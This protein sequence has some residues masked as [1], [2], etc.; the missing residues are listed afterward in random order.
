MLYGTELIESLMLK[1]EK[2]SQVSENS[3]ADDDVQ[4]AGEIV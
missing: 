1:F 3:D 2:I 4:N